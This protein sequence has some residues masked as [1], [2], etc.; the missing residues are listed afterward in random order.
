MAK[1]EIEI[2]LKTPDELIK[3]D[4]LAIINENVIKYRDNDVS[5]VIKQ[6]GNRIIMT[7]ENNE[8]Q[9]KLEFQENKKTLG[10]Y[11]LK[12]NNIMLELEIL[13]KNLKID[14]KTIYIMYQLHDEIREYRV[15]VKE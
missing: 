9:L 15:S 12:D 5:V 11:L 3:N 4:T 7:R 14:K 2:V 13:T 8:Y 1:K 10:N 6:D